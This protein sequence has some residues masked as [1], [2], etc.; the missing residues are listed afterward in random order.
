MQ[1]L[2]YFVSCVSLKHQSITFFQKKKTTTKNQQQ[3]ESTVQLENL[4][5]YYSLPSTS[6]YLLL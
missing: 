4:F 1:N 5:R 3:Q 2:G 6:F